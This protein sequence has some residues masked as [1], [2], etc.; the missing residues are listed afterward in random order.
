MATSRP[1]SCRARATLAHAAN[2]EEVENV[3]HAEPLSRQRRLGR[4]VHES[5]PSREPALRGNLLPTQ[6][7]PAATPLP[8]ATPRRPGRLHAGTT[9]AR[10][11]RAQARQ[12]NPRNL[13]PSLGRHLRNSRRSH[14]RASFQ[15]RMTVSGEIQHAAVSSTLRPPKKR[16]STTRLLRSSKPGERRQRLVECHQIFCFVRHGQRVGDD[17]RM[18]PPPRF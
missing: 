6:V 10:R 11:S 3:I 9:P 7:A 8:A 15:S 17:T 13:L 14:V 5:R 1:S 18:A 2:A 4:I 16:N 12:I